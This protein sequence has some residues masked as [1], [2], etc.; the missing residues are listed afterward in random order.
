MGRL[1]EYRWYFSR[2]YILVNFFLFVGKVWRINKNYGFF[3]YLYFK[4]YLGFFLYFFY[5][6]LKLNFRGK[7]DYNFFR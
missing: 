3:R 7:L 2:I 6:G 1:Y 5:C 4:V